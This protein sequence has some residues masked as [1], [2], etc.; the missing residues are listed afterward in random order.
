MFERYITALHLIDPA[1]ED[2]AALRER[3]KPN[4]PPRAVRRMT[5]L[6][7]MVGSAIQ[8]VANG[9]QQAMIYSSEYGESVAL[10]GYL[11]SFPTA[12]PTLFQTSIHPSAFQQALIQQQKPLPEALPMAG[13]PELVLQSALAAVTG[14][15]DEVIWCGGDECGTW[16][17]ELGCAADR[18]FAFAMALRRER[19]DQSV[20]RL[21]LEPTE[22][23]GQ[24]ALAQ[25]FDLLREHRSWS[26]PIGSG[27]QLSIDWS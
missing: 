1:G 27:W 22:T 21:R 8:K 10:E 4:F 19:T 12:S 3:L 15:A 26:G 7:L 14:E 23:T 17:R 25:W 2:N 24:M 11:R 9:D 20:G 13:G 16:L 18:S 5:L 6:G